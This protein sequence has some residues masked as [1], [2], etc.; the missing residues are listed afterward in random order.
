MK[1]LL[2]KAGSNYVFNAGKLI[3]GQVEIKE[4]ALKRQFDI[5]M[6]IPR[7][8]CYSVVVNIPEGYS[9]EGIEK[10]N[11][12]VQ[13]PSGSFKAKA[14]MEGNKLK[15]EVAKV[16]NHNFEKKE[17]W[18]SMVE[19]LDACYDFTETKIFIKKK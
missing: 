11:F 2:Q 10:L 9:A 5:Y 19:F 4:D 16:Y 15:I 7:S 18:A 1:E 17:D 3:G 12:D 8:F 6:L 13:K 14:T